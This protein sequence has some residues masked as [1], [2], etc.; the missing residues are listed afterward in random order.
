[1]RISFLILVSSR[2]RHTRCALVTGV[3]TCALP[4][5]AARAGRTWPPTTA[6]STDP[7]PRHLR[8][9]GHGRSRE[10]VRATIAVPG[11]APDRRRS[12]HR[13]GKIHDIRHLLHRR[14]TGGFARP[15]RA[16][17]IYPPGRTRKTVVEGH[18]V[19]VS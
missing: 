8:G 16:P 17:R 6:S 5:S 7:Y 2:R 3:Q 9:N 1:M 10:P 18:E 14:P 4:I 19:Y 13:Q 11:T 15:V 12:I